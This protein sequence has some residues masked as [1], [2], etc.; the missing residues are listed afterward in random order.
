MDESVRS[1]ETFQRMRTRKERRSFG[2][3][4]RPAL[5]DADRVKRHAH[6]PWSQNRVLRL[7]IRR[8]ASTDRAVMILRVLCGKVHLYAGISSSVCSRRLTTRIQVSNPVASEGMGKDGGALF[9]VLIW[10]EGM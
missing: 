6:R 8:K 9:F 3:K 10:Q 1:T 2:S 7:I 4:P 5:Y